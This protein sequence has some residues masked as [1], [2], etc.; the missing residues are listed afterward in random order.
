MVF[1][2]N[3]C[4]SFKVIKVASSNNKEIL[5]DRISGKYSL[6]ISFGNPYGD[7]DVSLEIYYMNSEIKSRAS[8]FDGQK[9]VSVKINSTELFEGA[10]FIN[11]IDPEV[12]NVEME[13]YFDDENSISG[14]YAGEYEFKGKKVN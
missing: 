8:Y 9:N 12:G 11:L 1:S 10:I 4:L 6:T 2:L 7:I 5:K 13:I 3:S 14:F